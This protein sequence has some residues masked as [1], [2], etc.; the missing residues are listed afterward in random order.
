M[1]IKAYHLHDKFFFFLRV[2]L[3]EIQVLKKSVYFTKRHLD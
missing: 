2:V 1:D 3:F